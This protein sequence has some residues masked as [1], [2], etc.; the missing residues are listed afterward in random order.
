MFEGLKVSGKDAAMM[1]G[2]GGMGLFGGIMMLLVF[3][4]VVMLVVWV[5]RA[6]I[7]SR[8]SSV[9]ETPLGIL[10]RRYAAGEINQA[11]F[12]QARRVLDG[13]GA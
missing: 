4:A 13:H 11:E 1:Y 7:P 8:H 12:D 3:V 10:T 2:F 5:V 9:G 6:G